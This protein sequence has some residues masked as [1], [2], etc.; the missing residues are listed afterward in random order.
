[1]PMLL[2]NNLQTKIDTNQEAIHAAMKCVVK[3]GWIML[4]PEIK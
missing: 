4:N 1:M 2:I 3:S